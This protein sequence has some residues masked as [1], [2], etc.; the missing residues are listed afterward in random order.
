MSQSILPASNLKR[1][2]VEKPILTGWALLLI[3]LA[4]RLI[5]IFGLR[6]D[7]SLGEIILS[8]SLGF[9]L[10]VIFV[11]GTGRKLKDIGFHSRFLFRS[12]FIG[13]LL[14][15]IAFV[16]GYGIE[17][18]SQLQNRAH[19]V[20]HFDAID[21]KAGVSGGVL[22]AIW[23]VFGNCVNSFMEEGL[24]RGL[25]IRLFRIR[26]SFWQTNWLQAFL[27]GMWHLPWVLKWYQTGTV[28]TSDEIAFAIISNFVPQLFM[29][30]VWGYL[31]L[32]TDNLWA[33][34]IGHTLTNS[35]LNLLHITTVD[36]IDSGITIRMV[37]Y[38]IVAVLSMPLVKHL[39]KRFQ[40]PEAKSWDKQASI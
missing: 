19:P 3:A 28:V 6:L 1:F 23:L 26:F 20:L 27:F 8:K 40:M 35:T 21:P 31:Y 12:L 7:E 22:F 24:F 34:W 10:I 33:A 29:G 39:A 16:L 18:S 13:I 30:I 38:I 25:M 17:F 14:T 11:W 9:A 15:T 5:D 4:L 37:V 32:K 36:G 2:S